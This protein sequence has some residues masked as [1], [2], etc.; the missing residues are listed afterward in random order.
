MENK[1]KIWE[2]K[3][4]KEL[5][6][7]VFIVHGMGE[8]SK[9]YDGVGNFLSEEGYKVGMIDLKGHGTNIENLEYLGYAND[10]FE[11]MIEE[12][13]EAIEIFRNKLG[14]KPLFILGHSMGSFITQAINE[15]GVR[16][17]GI[18]L[19][20]SGRPRKMS[21]KFA[22]YLSSLFLKIGN[23]RNAF[24]NKLAFGLYNRKFHGSDEFRWLSRDKLSVKE[25]QKDILCGVLPYTGYFKGLFHMIERS[26]AV[27]QKKKYSKTPIYMFSG[28]EDPVGEYGRGTIRLY[29]FYKKLG[30]KN[31]ELKLY[32]NGRHEM[33][34]EL[35]KNEVLTELLDWLDRRTIR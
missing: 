5:K 1:I 32:Q 27:G 3:I 34:Q 14:N 10:N 7:G 8:Y 20:G 11:V 31:V 18:I 6:G 13:V 35:N 12:L 33:L 17:H 28:E 22:Y 19:S 4:N 23:K 29:N 15:S 26:L 30:Y 2:N 16:S 21:I 24:I 9:R 25:Y